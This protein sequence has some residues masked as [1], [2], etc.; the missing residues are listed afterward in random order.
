[1]Q[2]DNFVD[3]LTT[4]Q[5]FV[6]SISYSNFLD[7]QCQ[8]IIDIKYLLLKLDAQINCNIDHSY[9]TKKFCELLKINTNITNLLNINQNNKL[10]KIVCTDQNWQYIPEPTCKFVDHYNEW[11]TQKITD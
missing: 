5:E 1:M 10:W 2:F 4:A 6:Y 9:V 11:I 3:Q 8:T 7:T